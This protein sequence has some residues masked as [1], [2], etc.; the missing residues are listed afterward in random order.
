MFCKVEKAVSSTHHFFLSLLC[1]FS[2]LCPHIFPYSIEGTAK[3]NDA[4]KPGSEQSW[5]FL[6]KDAQ[7]L[8]QDSPFDRNLDY[9]FSTSFLLTSQNIAHLPPKSA[10]KAYFRAKNRKNAL[11][12]HFFRPN[13]CM[14]QKEFVLLHRNWVMV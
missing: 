14:F 6:R 7:A 11:F 5:R 2:S 1:R 12:S 13:S 3:L 10:S 9:F 4:A 8:Q